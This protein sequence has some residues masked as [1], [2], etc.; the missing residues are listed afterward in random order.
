M[1]KPIMLIIFTLCLFSS[2]SFA[3]DT[4]PFAF[5]CDSVHFGV[6]KFKLQKSSFF[7]LNKKGGINTEL[8]EV[9]APIKRKYRLAVLK[10]ILTD[11]N[12]FT[13]G[14]SESLMHP[15][16]FIFYKKGKVVAT[17]VPNMTGCDLGLSTFNR[18]GVAWST[19]GLKN[20]ALFCVRQSSLACMDSKYGRKKK[21]SLK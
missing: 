8:F 20:L 5:N 17:L 16:V 2:Y 9:I 18:S 13:Q 19:A 1:R 6:V 21:Q 10:T 3:A 4:P 12:S 11:R 15:Y 14:L 7:V